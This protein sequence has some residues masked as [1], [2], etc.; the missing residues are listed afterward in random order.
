MPVFLS[1]TRTFSKGD[2]NMKDHRCWPF[3]FA[4]VSALLLFT[5]TVVLAGP[6]LICHSFDIGSAR[7]LPWI[8]H[9]WNLSGSETYDTSK[10]VS[11][12]AAILAADN[13]VL[14]H[15]ETLRRATLYARKDPAVAKA[16]LNR[17]MMATKSPQPNES[18]ALTYFD[19]GYLAEAYKQWLGDSSNN[20]AAGI[21]GYALVKEAIQL[22]RNDPQME[23]AAALISLSR[24]DAEHQAHAQKAIAGAKSDPLLAR[25]L[26]SHFIGNQG[27]TIAELLTKSTVAE[28]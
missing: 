23:F 2:P 6:P 1:G 15:M 19:T 14:V 22:R 18:R 27:Q 21:D 7:S 12:T 16:L 17:V 25:N 20:P 10:L 4:A 11:D 9:S 5:V 24:P 26:A 8:S 3:R 28:K 13:T